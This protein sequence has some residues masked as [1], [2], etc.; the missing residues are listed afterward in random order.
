METSFIAERKSSER[1]DGLGEVDKHLAWIGRALRRSY[2]GLG[3]RMIDGSSI[4]GQ[5]GNPP[6][7]R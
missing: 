7:L 1:R 2:A 6:L 3:F 4:A 5:R